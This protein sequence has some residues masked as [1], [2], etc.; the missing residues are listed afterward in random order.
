MIPDQ[1]AA[2]A[3]EQ[4]RVVPVQHAGQERAF[5]ELPYRLY[6]GDA[7]WAPP[8]RFEESRRW[9]RQHH[10]SLRYRWAR[11]F[12]AR[13]D[14][15][16][17]G[18]IA[19]IIDRAFARRWGP[20]TGFFGFFECDHDPVAAHRLLEAAER[21]L[22]EKGMRRI[23]GPV[24]LTTHD[25]TGLQVEGFG[26][27]PMLLSPYNPSYYS[28]LLE[29][30]GYEGASDY[31][32]YL[33]TPEYRI[34]AAVRRLV[35]AAREGKGVAA[36]ITVRPLDRSRWN[37]E[38][39]GFFELYN[40]SFEGV[41]GSVPIRWDEFEERARRFRPFLLPELVLFAEH[42]G[43]PI[44]CALTLPD[45]NDLLRRVRGRLLPFGWLELARG[46]G[47]IRSAR[48]MILGV[49]PRFT[50]RGVGAMLA[51]ETGE[52]LRRLGFERAELSLVQGANERM[53]RV[54]E[55]FGCPRLKTFRL[56]GKRLECGG[57]D[58]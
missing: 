26:S 48:V 37:Q 10:A 28:D 11:R 29:A 34:G 12:V 44:G 33:W 39:R 35:G 32:S 27:P 16:V 17:V 2:E 22:W 24:N 18:R 45:L 55:A 46:S 6:R 25:E 53:R 56:Y 23:V 3:P 43:R 31:H 38:I 13:R 58:R 8:L 9:C 30:F 42:E 5:R 15:R 7:L 54:I 49:H 50:G 21:T 36:G 14:D 20:R 4:V 47:G 51:Y 57:G 52:A 40:A 19:A 41:W 1:A